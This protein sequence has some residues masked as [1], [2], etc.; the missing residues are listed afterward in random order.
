MSDP[1]GMRKEGV[2]VGWLLLLV[3]VAANP[4]LLGSLMFVD[5]E[6]P[7]TFW[8]I[9]GAVEVVLAIVGVL[10]LIGKLRFGQLGRPVLWGSSLM[11]LL[12]GA[13]YADRLLGTLGKRPVDNGLIF[14]PHSEALL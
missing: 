9:V 10:V 14:P 6:P 4:W 8:L 3:A 11:V 2:I 7:L 12:F 13:I 1:N 5:D